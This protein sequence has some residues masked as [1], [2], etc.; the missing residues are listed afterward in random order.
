MAARDVS[1]PSTDP[2]SN[3]SNSTL[4]GHRLKR[5]N[6]LLKTKL[7]C[8]NRLDVVSLNEFCQFG[9]GVA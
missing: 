2:H 9:Q 5:L 6:R 7:M 3:L 8:N 1:I 4:L